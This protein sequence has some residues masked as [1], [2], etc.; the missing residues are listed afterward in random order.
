MRKPGLFLEWLCVRF[1]ALRIKAY[2]SLSSL[3]R[4]SSPHV[5]LRKA[6]PKNSHACHHNVIVV[7]NQISAV[8]ACPVI[9][10]QMS[11]ACAQRTESVEWQALIL[12]PTV[13]ATCYHFF[14]TASYA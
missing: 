13:S 11:V 14:L 7:V 10:P 5:L 4:E 1:C 3:Y 2:V 9:H 12:L 6:Q 8:T